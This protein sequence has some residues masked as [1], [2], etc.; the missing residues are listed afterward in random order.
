M[1]SLK[2]ND[3]MRVLTIIATIM[4]TLT[5][6]TG[7]YGMNFR[8]MPELDTPYGYFAVLGVMAL[9]AIGLLAYFKKKNWI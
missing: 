2:T 8:F 1:T 5:V 4:M 6:V 9:I 7:I 3:I